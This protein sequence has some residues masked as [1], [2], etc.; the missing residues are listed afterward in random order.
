[1]HTKDHLTAE[2]RAAGLEDLAARAE[3]GWYH[4]FDS[5]LPAPALELSRDLAR[6][7]SPAAMALLK[8]Q[9]TG[10]FDASEAEAAAWVE[11]MMAARPLPPS[12]PNPSR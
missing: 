9:L 3:I 6:N 2:L 12:K 5:P 8:R 4:D 10:E 11:G 1:M 7:G